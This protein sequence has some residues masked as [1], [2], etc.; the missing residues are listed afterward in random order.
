MAAAML[1]L[2]L[3]N[4]LNSIPGLGCPQAKIHILEPYR[5]EILVKAPQAVPRVASRHEECAG[6]LL[7]RALEI[8]IPIQV[9]IT[10]VDR[11][12]RPQTVDSQKLEGQG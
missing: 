5:V 12:S 9:S 1:R 2:N 3:R 6:G 8:Q 11:I 4:I 10:P 7:H